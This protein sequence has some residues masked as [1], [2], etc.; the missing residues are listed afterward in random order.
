MKLP[1]ASCGVSLAE[2]RRSHTRL[3]SHEL[4][5]GRLAIP[6][7]SKLQSILAKAN[8]IS[9]WVKIILLEKGFNGDD[10]D[11]GRANTVTLTIKKIF[12]FVL[13][14]YPK[15]NKTAIQTVANSNQA[16]S[17]G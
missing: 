15:L 6:L 17:S 3:R 11:S 16:D 9:I 13:P 12:R 14:F 4:R 7:C 1:A 10:S 8:E 5:R 2:F